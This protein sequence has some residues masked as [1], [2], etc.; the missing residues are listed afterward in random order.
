MQ[1]YTALRA[2]LSCSFSGAAH[3][4]NA[5]QYLL[6]TALRAFIIALILGASH[7]ITNTTWCFAPLSPLNMQG[8]ICSF[9]GASHHFT[10]ANIL[11]L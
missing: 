9:Y 10:A 4:F 1:L 7:L 6:L 2:V 5:A 3:H 11:A 8:F